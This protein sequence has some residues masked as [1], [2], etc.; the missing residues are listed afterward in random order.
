LSNQTDMPFFFV[1]DHHDHGQFTDPW[2]PPA[3]IQP[4]EIGQWRTES[5]GIMTGTEGNARYST[6]VIDGGGNA[7]T[8]FIES[9]WDNPYVGTNEASMSVVADFTN[10]PST[11]LKAA[12]FIQANGAEP[13][14][15][16]K[17][18]GGDVEAWVDGI[19]FPPYIIANWNTASFNDANAFYAV[20]VGSTPQ[21]LG[22]FAGPSTGTK[23]QKLNTKANPAEWA[24]RWNSPDV[25][26]TLVQRGGKS[27]TAYITDRSANPVLQFEQQFEL[28]VLSWVSDHL[29][30]QAIDTHLAGGSEPVAKV[31][32]AATARSIASLSAQQEQAPVDLFRKTALAAAEASAI[33]LSPTRLERA[34]KTITS[35]VT[36]TR[37]TLALSNGVYLS[38]Y[39]TFTGAQKTGGFI[40]YERQTPSGLL[41]H[42]AQLSYVIDLH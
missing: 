26:V 39:D 40:Q 41:L 12:W 20:K 37:G 38:L 34:A 17:M 9:Y 33:H 1:S 18:M 7:H 28:G 32:R 31:L 35:Y 21:F 42:T 2:F 15:W 19:L 30:V 14:N 36:K 6:G 5:D 10:K 8:E 13:P 11:T 3:V 4:G 27:M 23:S 16:A 29:L 24:G 22:E 25:S